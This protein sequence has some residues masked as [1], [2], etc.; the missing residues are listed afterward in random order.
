MHARIIAE[1]IPHARL[2]GVYDIS[3]DSAHEVADE[4]RVDAASSI[5]EL[6]AAPGVDALA[7]CTATNTHSELIIKAAHAGKAVF[8]EKPV[9]LSLSDVDEA[10]AAVGA[11]GV[12]FMVGFNRRFDPGHAAVRQAARSGEL[13][14]LTMA[15]I[16]SRDPSPPPIEYVRVSG[17]IWVDMLIHDFDMANFIVGS[18]VVQIW[19]QGAALIDEGIRAAGDV[20]TAVAVLTHASGAI[21]TIDASRQAPYGYDQRVEALGTKGMALSDN[22]RDNN[23]Q[24]FVEGATRQAPFQHFFLERYTD[25][26]RLEWLAFTDYALNGGPSP[27]SGADGRAPIVMAMAADLSAK[28]GRPVRLDEIG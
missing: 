21:T 18:P 9:S 27:V 11:A 15:R 24:V 6:L 5:D 25:S 28:E 12:P 19:A 23:A 14:E 22:R 8:C 2:T 1:Q 26:Y 16:T 3:A 17:G 7:I 20:D 4:L 13:G 10:I